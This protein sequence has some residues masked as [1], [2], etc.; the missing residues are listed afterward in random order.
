MSSKFTVAPTKLPP[1]CKSLIEPLPPLIVAGVPTSLQAYVHCLDLDPLLPIPVD[2]CE[3]IQLARVPGAPVWSGPTRPAYWEVI[4]DVTLDAPPDRFRVA[5]HLF[6]ESAFIE[7]A[8]WFPV[9]VDPDRPFDTGDLQIVTAP[10]IDYRK[11]RVM[12]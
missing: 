6:E 3:L 1:Q 4:C 5:L 10:G 7:T 8:E 2:V 9:Y 11:C 12:A